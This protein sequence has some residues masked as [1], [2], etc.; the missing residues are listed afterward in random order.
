MKVSR[1]EIISR[2]LTHRCPN[3]GAK[4]L[5]KPGSYFTLNPTC[6]NC[7]MD[8]DKDGAGFLGATALNYGIS[9]F[10]IILPL[11]AVAYFSGMPATLLMVLLIIAA[12]GIPILLY[13]ASKSWWIMCYYYFL[14]DHLPANWQKSPLDDVP[15]DE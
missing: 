1:G 14:P 2:G 11:M 8:W 12:I 3:C 5:F 15:P 13:R 10:V 7:G 6:A 9:V 4:T